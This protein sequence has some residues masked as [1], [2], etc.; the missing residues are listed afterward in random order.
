MS[1]T[2]NPFF[3]LISEN[4]I[5][6]IGPHTLKNG[7]KVEYYFNTKKIYS[8]PTTLD[9]I[10]KIMSNTVKT[11]T[12]DDDID[13]NHIIGVPY[14]ALPLATLISQ[15]LKK[16]LL[17]TRKEPKS[18][19]TQ[20]LIEGNYEIGDSII[21][22][23]DVITSGSSIIETI[24]KLEN[25]GLIVSLVVVLF[26]RQTGGLLD[27]EEQCK[28]PVIEIYNIDK[29]SKYL[30]N[31][32]Y[33]NEF[34][35]GK[36]I[37]S[38]AIEKKNHMNN[39][40]IR[41]QTLDNEEKRLESIKNYD[42]IMNNP[43][44]KLLMGLVVKK[45]SALCLSLDVDKWEVGKKILNLCGEYIVMV[46]LHVDLFTDIINID[47]FIK[48][49]RELG[50]K[51]QF[52]IME[53]IKLA[54]VDKITHKKINN[55]FFK[56]HTWAN[57][58]TIHGLTSKSVVDSL[59]CEKLVN[60]ES[61]TCK[62]YEDDDNY[63][64]RT[65]HYMDDNIFYNKLSLVTDM[66]QK[67]SFINDDY[68]EQCRNLLKQN[69]EINCVISQDGN[70]ITNKV[71]LTPGVCIDNVDGSRNY[72]DIKTAIED[73]GNHIIIVGSGILQYYENQEEE[74]TKKSKDTKDNNILFMEYVQK[75]A[76]YSYYSFKSKYNDLIIKL[77][78]YDNT[79]RALKD[80]YK[81]DYIETKIIIKETKLELK[82]KQLNITE[83]KLNDNIE[84]FKEDKENMYKNQFYTLISMIA[85]TFYFNYN[86]VIQ[87]LL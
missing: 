28:V 60:K 65:N 81:I 58:L 25:N 48:E 78:D 29:I 75:Y 34:D 30:K 16:P 13:Y 7:D 67:D 42:Y 36:I 8:N 71:K 19:G 43:L 79:D 82:E 4:N 70:K 61:C 23:E 57:Y 24:K 76:G 11:Y 49:I 50:R 77:K 44:E 18:Y 74:D 87:Y 55:S 68:R 5:I 1:T 10:G 6:D 22:V 69:D 21:L 14:G 35:Y 86:S 26:N 52:L 15:N 17:F 39:L 54:D 73:D 33:I 62:N 41:K 27:V 64:C 31:N 46:K 3:D 59:T 80:L 83:K 51:H 53:D 72:R 84:E 85:V 56:Y 32:N 20:K 37:S 45:Q 12:E 40:Q 38:I 47:L 66:N 9:Y 2:S 63:N